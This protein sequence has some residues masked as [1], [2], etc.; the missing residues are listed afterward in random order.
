MLIKKIQKFFSF[1]ERRLDDSDFE[2]DVPLRPHRSEHRK[3]G[4]L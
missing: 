4:D 1:P 3:D 2:P